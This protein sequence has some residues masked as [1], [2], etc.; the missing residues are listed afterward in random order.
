MGK[1]SKKGPKGGAAPGDDEESGM[2]LLL[3]ILALITGGVL[4]GLFKHY[5]RQ[6]ENGERFGCKMFGIDASTWTD[7][8]KV[9]Y[10][11]KWMEF[12]G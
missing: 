4:L 2:G 7:K 8:D 3:T 5:S 9:G 6:G 1:K 11:P 10:L 12:H